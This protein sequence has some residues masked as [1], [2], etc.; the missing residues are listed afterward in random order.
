MPNTAQ[1]YRSENDLQELIPSF[2]HVGTRDRILVLRF[3]NKCPYPLSH[4]TKKS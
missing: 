4:L 2:Q 1:V 3:G